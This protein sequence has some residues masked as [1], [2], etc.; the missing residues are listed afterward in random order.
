MASSSRNDPSYESKMKN[1]DENRE[2]VC[3][4]YGSKSIGSNSGK[5]STKII[6]QMFRFLKPSTSILIHLSIL[7]SYAIHVE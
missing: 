1:H 6:D 5:I 4:A 7:M 3:I 2:K